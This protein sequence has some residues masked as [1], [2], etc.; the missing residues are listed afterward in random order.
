RGEDVAGGAIVALEPDHLG[1]GEVLLEAQDVVDLGAAPA[2]DRLVVV[3]Y[4]ADVLRRQQCRRQ[5]LLG[6]LFGISIGPESGVIGSCI[7]LGSRGGSSIGCGVRGSSEGEL[8]GRVGCSRV[9]C[10]GGSGV[11]ISRAIMCSLGRAL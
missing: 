10:R 4:A 8:P 3:A 2:V 6:V 7:G 9:G 1:A 11:S 5:M